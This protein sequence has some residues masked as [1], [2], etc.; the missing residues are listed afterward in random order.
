MI[1]C[2][3]HYHLEHELNELGKDFWEVVYM[4][5][6]GYKWTVVLKKEINHVS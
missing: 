5:A 3:Y 4:T 2:I 6:E 1:K